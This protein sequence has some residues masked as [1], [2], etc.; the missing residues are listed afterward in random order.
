LPLFRYNKGV[1]KFL[2]SNLKKGI[3]KVTSNSQF[4]YTILVAILIVS[5]F[6]F[7]SE[8]FIGIANDAQERLINVR[9][10]SLQ[11]AFVSFAGEKIDDTEYLN[12][13]IDYIIKTNETMKNFKIITKRTTALPESGVASSAHIVIASSNL[14]EINKEDTEAS[15]LYN[16]ASSDPAHSITIAEHAGGERLF[17]T[18]RAI[19][20]E[21]GN[22]LGVVTTTQTLS[23]AATA[24][25][26]SSRASARRPCF[27]RMAPRLLNSQPHNES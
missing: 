6:V 24:A 25:R 4:I 11:D 26:P 23:L 1:L 12:K 18:S 15:F 5:S 20:D 2:Y 17:K 13:K 14:E 7:M 10:G 8:R 16:L 22:I 21:S 27:E 3:E 9:I 19:A